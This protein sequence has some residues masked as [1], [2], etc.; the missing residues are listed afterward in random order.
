MDL[1]DKKWLFLPMEHVLILKYRKFL[2]FRLL[3]EVC[4]LDT[5]LAE[6]KFFLQELQHVS[7][8]EFKS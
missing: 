2:L 3:S 5:V 8:M 4:I 1:G 6:S 7:F